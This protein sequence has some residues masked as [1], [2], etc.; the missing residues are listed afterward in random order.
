M[1]SLVRLKLDQDTDM[2]LLGDKLIQGAV[3]SIDHYKILKI[4]SVGLVASYM[5]MQIRLKLYLQCMKVK[6]FNQ[7]YI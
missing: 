1:D 3:L 4:H 6:C 7:T 5:N 2:T